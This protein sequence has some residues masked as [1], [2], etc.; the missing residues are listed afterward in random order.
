MTAEWLT[1]IVDVLKTGGPWAILVILGLAY[2]KKDQ[3]CTSAYL[4]MKDLSVAQ[5]AAMTKLKDAI[6]QLTD[7]LH[8]FLQR[9][10]DG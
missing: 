3:E 2:W 7:T 5:T 9:N 1:S 6:S 10:K 8:L 4:L